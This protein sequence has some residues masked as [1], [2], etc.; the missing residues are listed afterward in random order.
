[1]SDF[2]RSDRVAGQLHSALSQVLREGVRD[3]RVAPITLTH[4]R[5]SDDLRIARVNFVPL[6]GRGDVEE[7]TAGLRAA[8]GYLRRQ[9]GQRLKLKYVPE[10]R[11]HVDEVLEASF[12]MSQ[13]LDKLAADRA[14]REGE[15]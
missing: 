3:P 5:M 9:V 7:I 12:D 8:G 10:L 6:G 1:M 14:A 2:K 4:I 11:F 15:E 13:T